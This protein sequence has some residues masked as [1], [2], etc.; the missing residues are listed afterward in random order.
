MTDG[1]TFV[2]TSN[3]PC[4]TASLEHALSYPAL[5]F[6]FDVLRKLL[7]DPLVVT[8]TNQP[9]DERERLR[10][11]TKYQRMRRDCPFPPEP[12]WA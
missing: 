7:G 2:L 8:P 9:V 6:R 11:F 1:D 3:R 4:A 12:D 5:T 10:A